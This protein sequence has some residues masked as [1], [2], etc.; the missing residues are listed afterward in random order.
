[1]ANNVYIGMR[2][3]PKFVGNWDSTMQTVYEP[4][5]IVMYNNSTYTS[6]QEVPTGINITNTTY[7][8]LTGNY[9][10]QISNLQSQIDTINNVDLPAIQG[11]ITDLDTDVSRLVAGTK[12]IILI[13][14][15]YLFG[16]LG[17]P[18]YGTKL[19]ALMANDNIYLYPESGSGFAHAGVDGNTFEDLLDDAISAHTTDANLITDVIAIGGS[20]DINQT[21]ATMNSAFASYVAKANTAF[22][23]AKVHIGFL[24]WNDMSVN[25]ASKITYIASKDQYLNLGTQNK[26]LYIVGL[27]NL[28]HNY[29][30]FF[31]SGHPNEACNGKIARYLL[32]YLKTGNAQLVEF[33][34]SII[35]PATGF[36]ADAFIGGAQVYTTRRDGVT[37][38]NIHGS[39]QTNSF[40]AYGYTFSAGTIASGGTLIKLA[41]LSGGLIYGVDLSSYG[42]VVAQAC[43]AW[44]YN[45]STW[46]N[47]SGSVVVVAHQLMFA[48]AQGFTDFS[49]FTGIRLPATKIIV[50]TMFA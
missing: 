5:S 2:Y 28:V 26:M 20:N 10:G 30:Q 42:H 32:D 4:L 34:D 15:S 31:N 3:V 38:V 50:D 41:D 24:G 12:N 23:N 45:G 21:D 47:V 48:P 36:T 17:Y 1:M 16:G 8:V 39:F 11:D 14:D 22:P 33:G 43:T 29:S 27:E 18:T 37:E 35:T 44:F 46:T 9:N 19:Q 49:Q 6:K 13:G 7:W 40:G 25:S